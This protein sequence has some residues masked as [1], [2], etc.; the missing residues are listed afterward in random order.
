[1]ASERY[2]MEDASNPCLNIDGLG[3]I[4]LPLSARE[5][6]AVRALAVPV[7][8]APHTW[9]IPL[10]KCKFDNHSWEPWIQGTVGSKIMNLLAGENDTQPILRPHR[11]CL[12]EAESPTDDSEDKI[13]CLF[14]ILPSLFEGG[15]L[16]LRH[17][18]E[19]KI[20]NLAH[21]S[22]V[23][24]FVAGTFTGVEHSMSPVSSGYRLW[25]EY[26]LIQPM[27]HLDEKPCLPDMQG[28]TRALRHLMVSWKQKKN[29]HQPPFLAVLLK[30]K[31][32]RTPNFGAKTLEGSD[33]LLVSRL[34]NLARGLKFRL[35]L[36][37]V[38]QK[39]CWKGELKYR[40]RAGDYYYESDGWGSS[41]DEEDETEDEHEDDTKLRKNKYDKFGDTARP[42]RVVEIMK[43]DGMPVNVEKLILQDDDLLNGSMTDY[44]P[45]QVH[46]KKKR[47]A[48][49]FAV[50]IAVQSR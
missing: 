27:T 2:S 26:D 25:L 5:A 3:P 47:V 32:P 40:Y 6:I 34:R 8:M 43:L 24:T 30:H 17:D 1:M 41:E 22:G 15:Q 11:L 10:K 42:L 12:Y 46:V 45:D 9:E 29:P 35:Y 44:D 28:P 7:P 50:H 13:G 16:E 33:A 39:Y 36:V 49:F 14:V 4:G 23:S 19:I 18:G 31:Y 20:L 37:H 38:E 48:S 21:L